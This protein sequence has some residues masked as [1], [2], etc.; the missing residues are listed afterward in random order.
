MMNADLLLATTSSTNRRACSFICSSHDG[1]DKK[2]S[3][4][5]E[6]RGEMTWENRQRTII[7]TRMCMVVAKRG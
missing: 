5:R 1:N 2:S 7:E 6:G 4:A 3:A